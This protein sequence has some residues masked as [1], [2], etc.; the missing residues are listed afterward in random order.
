MRRIPAL[1]GSALLCLAA[2]APLLAQQGSAELRGRVSDESGGA[3]P[4]AT[5]VVRHQES[6]VF[7]QATSGTDGSYFL[8]GVVPGVY[9]LNVEMDGFKRYSR[10]DLK[11][12]IGKTA[13]VDARRS[14]TSRRRRWAATSPSAS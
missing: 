9:E 3:L 10:R 13:T 1:I 2:A 8:A 11:L 4:G 6:G 7:R 5:V 14:S 12:E